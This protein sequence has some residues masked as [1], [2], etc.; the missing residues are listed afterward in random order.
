MLM[1]WSSHIYQHALQVFLIQWFCLLGFSELQCWPLC[2]SF[3]KYN[4]TLTHSDP[5][6]SM[7]LH[8]CVLLHKKS[9][10]LPFLITAALFPAVGRK[11]VNSQYMFYLLMHDFWKTILKLPGWSACRLTCVGFLYS[12]SE[13]TPSLNLLQLF[14]F[15]P[16]N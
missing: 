10:L 7:Q 13:R 6:T 11:E 16:H 14:I 5:S 2:C 3:S 9:S 15:V 4:R 8:Q 1:D 12:L